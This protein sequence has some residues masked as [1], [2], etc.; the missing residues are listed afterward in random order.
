M[1]YNACITCLRFIVRGF[2]SSHFSVMIHSLHISFLIFLSITFSLPLLLL[3]LFQLALAP[4]VRT[5]SLPLRILSREYGVDMVYS[6]ETVDLK[7]AKCIRCVDEATG[8]ISYVNPS[9]NNVVNS[10]GGSSGAAP[11]DLDSLYKVFHTYPGERVV[12]QLGTGDAVSAL[13]AAEVVARDVRAIDINMGC[14]KLFSLQGAMGSALLTKP[15][16]VADIISTLK[17]NLNVPITCKIRLLSSPQQTVQL[18]QTAERCGAS[19]IAVHSRFRDDRP[20]HRAVPSLQTPLVVDAVSVPVIHNGDVFVWQDIDRYRAASGT[21]SV[22]IARGALWNPSVFGGRRYHVNEEGERVAPDTANYEG[23][24]VDACN[25]VDASMALE[26]TKQ[27]RQQSSSN[28]NSTSTSTS[29]SGLASVPVWRLS[30]LDAAARAALPRAIVPWCKPLYGYG[31]GPFAKDAAASTSAASKRAGANGQHVK[32]QESKSAMLTG[33]DEED[34]DDES[35]DNYGDADG[36]EA[37]TVRGERVM[38]RARAVDTYCPRN[39]NWEWEDEAEFAERAPLRMA[40]AMQCARRLVAVGTAVGNAVANTKYTLTEML[41]T[42]P[43]VSSHKDY[44]SLLASKT[45][46][47]LDEALEKVSDA[48]GAG[49]PLRLPFH[50]RSYELRPVAQEEGAENAKIH[51]SLRTKKTKKRA[52]EAKLL[53]L[54]RGREAKLHSWVVNEGGEGEA[55]DK[56]DVT[57]A[58]IS[59]STTASTVPTQDATAMISDRDGS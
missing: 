37:T 10:S 13:K 2:Y 29:S 11:V 4:M 17:R 6:E 52:A 14:P 54:E 36:N 15:E 18:V 31:G 48:P 7:L 46:E 26:E 45:F 8:L 5:G 38:L 43:K 12:L 40:P 49:F 16:V 3:L 34:N 19:A 56:G 59:D 30:P 21:N 20:R 9:S 58:S 1:I 32:G 28:S 39:L 22:M 33:K 47:A 24:D 35:D 25:D 23:W 42:Y 51:A 55:G 50:P 44:P 41:K 53:A 57:H 27:Q